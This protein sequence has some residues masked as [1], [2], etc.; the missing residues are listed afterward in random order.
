MSQLLRTQFG[1]RL[2][3]VLHSRG[4]KPVDLA[5]LTGESPAKVGGW[6]QGKGLMTQGLAQ[7]ALSLDVSLDWLI[8]GV[9]PERVSET[10]KLDTQEEQ[11]IWALR[12]YGDLATQHFCGL[13]AAVERAGITSTLQH[14]RAQALLADIDLPSVILSNSGCF[15]TANEAFGALLD[16]EQE[17]IS[18]LAGINY[19][20]WLPHTLR[21]EFAVLLNK[22][23]MQNNT[24]SNYVTVNIQQEGKFYLFNIYGRMFSDKDISGVQFVFFRI[25]K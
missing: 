15:L 20:K 9:G 22:T 24:D 12:Q 13:L 11:L 19:K 5:R 21:S 17:K 25:K 8:H 2:K 18:A 3:Q 23:L 6:L 10:L 14:M 7:L 1:D 4:L 16:F